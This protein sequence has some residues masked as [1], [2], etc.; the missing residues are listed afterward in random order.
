MASAL[1]EVLVAILR[2]QPAAVPI[3]LAN[4]RGSPAPANQAV[5]V[6]ASDL[7]DAVAPELRADLVMTLADDEGRTTLAMAVEVQLA[8]DRRKE[9]SWPCYLTGLRAR[10]RCEAA[11][12]VV[13]IDEDVARWARRPI[14]LGPENVFRCLV[15]GPAQVPLRWPNEAPELAL[16]AAL[17]HARDEADH[18]IRASWRAIDA[19]R[20]LDGDDMRL[21]SDLLFAQLGPAARAAVE[22]AMK[23]NVKDYEFQSDF[24][25][26]C[27]AR[28]LQRGL[29][30]G[31]LHARRS[32][33]I[34]ILT[35]RSIAVP[36]WARA[37]IDACSDRQR[38]DEW[39][40]R[41]ATATSLDDL[42]V[43]QTA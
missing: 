7:G 17:A 11:V 6:V 42:L 35:A 38:L 40:T 43:P 36:D 14:V 25:K 24:M 19:L 27:D 4:A 37:A 39:L 33:L 31:E 12:L 3:L 5:N 20:V 16:L 23:F 26:R 10:H 28:G 8:I 32:A 15:V 29:A 34:T 1:H 41:A 13:A 21:Y 2:E 18:A 30:E 9:T 22:A